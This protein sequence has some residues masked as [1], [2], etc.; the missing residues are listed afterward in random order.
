MSRLSLQ[1]LLPVT[2]CI[3]DTAAVYITVVKFR[4]TICPPPPQLSLH[5]RAA[6]SSN[7]NGTLS[8]YSRK[9]PKSLLYCEMSMLSPHTDI[10][11][12]IDCFSGLFRLYIQ[13][14][15]RCWIGWH[16]AALLWEVTAAVE[17]WE[18]I[19]SKFDHHNTV[20][21]YKAALSTINDVTGRRHHTATCGVEI[22]VCST[23]KCTEHT[24][25]F[26]NA[27]QHR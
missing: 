6:L 15:F 2:S 19:I 16:S 22:H 13:T 7:S 4:N 20:Y 24:K 12:Y 11:H 10:S 23:F 27:E 26:C 1:C 21:I 17:G 18:N 5:W 25:N 14:V 8:V 9:N 3:G